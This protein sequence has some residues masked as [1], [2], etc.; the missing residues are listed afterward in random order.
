[1]ARVCTI[2]SHGKRSE[3]EAAFVAGGSYRH[4]ASQF[5]V[6]Y[7][8]VERH[9]LE[10]I[11]QTIKASQSASEEAQ[12]IDV[13]KQLKEVNDVTIA[14][15]KESR[16]DKKNGTALFAIDRIQ[17]QLELQAKLLG[18]IDERPQINVWI[19]SEWQAI[20]TTIAR[21]LLPYP[22]A[23]IAVAD[24]LASLEATHARL[25]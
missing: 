8:S 12:A 16:A 15:M 23:R 3:I 24:A 18:D 5:D 19:T 22:D 2:C 6:G 9:S 21:A 1:M 20:R 17:K 4:I 11:A 25:N 14:I 7:K 10:H 13:V